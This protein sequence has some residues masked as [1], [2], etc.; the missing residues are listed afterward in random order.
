[1]LTILS[2]YTLGLVFAQQWVTNIGL[3]AL[4]REMISGSN[5]TASSKDKRGGLT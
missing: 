2:H 3:T 4:E 5:W 1:M